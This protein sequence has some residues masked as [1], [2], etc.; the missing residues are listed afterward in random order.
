MSEK[1]NLH[2]A[3][4]AIA[5]LNARDLDR[6]VKLIDNSYVG[7]SELA[8]SALHG[9]DAVR[10]MFETYFKAF[11]DLHFETEQILTSGDYL[12]ER[13]RVTGT[14]KGNL[15]GIAPTN[16]TINIQS[17]NVVEVRNGKIIR[18]RIYADNAKMLQQLGVLSL[19]KTTQ[20][21]G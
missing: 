7:E 14:H 1:D 13:A 20:A 8:P 2:L 16:K 5:A 18:S 10:Q 17:C 3:E 19:P 11:P 21:A 6:Y 12:V 15:M 9:P 4:Q